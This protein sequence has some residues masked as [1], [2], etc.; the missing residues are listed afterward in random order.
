MHV[1]WQQHGSQAARVPAGKLFTPLQAEIYRSSLQ[2][3]QTRDEQ[4]SGTIRQVCKEQLEMNPVEAETAYLPAPVSLE[5]GLA[6]AHWQVVACCCL[7]CCH[8]PHSMLL[9][10]QLAALQGLQVMLM[11]FAATGPCC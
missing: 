5:L 10:K 6:D 2:G 11:E 3:K 1:G 8:F 9:M 7:E 4:I